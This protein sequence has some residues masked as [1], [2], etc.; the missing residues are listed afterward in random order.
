MTNLFSTLAFSALIA[1]ALGVF[2]RQ[3]GWG[4]ALPLLAAGA[5]VGVAPIGPD[6]PPEPEVVLIAVLAPL[7]FGEALGSS[8]LDLRKV[9]RPVLALA[10]GLV[11]ATTLIVGA[12]ASLV[13][14]MPIAMAFALGAVL[15]PTDAVAVS[16]VARRA[17]LPRRLVSILEGESLVNDGTGLTALK[18]AIVAAAAGSVTLAE[19][20]L[21]F[22]LA[23]V[24]GVGVG[25]IGG[26]ALSWVL[27]RAKD[28]VSANALVLVAPFGLY[29]IAEDFEGSGILA[30]VV[31][32]LII[33]NRQTSD[34]GHAGR[35]QS[36]NLWKHITF[37]L[38]CLAFFLVGM[39]IPDVLGRTKEDHLT[40]LL[41]LVPVVLVTLIVVRTLF[42]FGM[43]GTSR[44][45]RR[46]G[47]NV[48]RGAIILSWAGARGPV[49]GLAAFSIPVVFASGQQVPFRDLI[50][51]TAFVI[52]VLTLLLSLTLAPLARALRVP[53]DD[54]V[55]LLARVDVRLARAALDRLTDVE[56]EAMEAGTPMD[57]A[58]SERLREAAE[59][60]LEVRSL[61]GDP[62]TT[63]ELATQ[64]LV[65]AA[66]AMIRAEQEELIAMRDG[67][68][69]PDA[70]VRPILQ[71]LDLR[72]Q[73]LRT[74]QR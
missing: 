37:A 44:A 74:E 68:G 2:L 27:R 12:V 61:P 3:R 10:I 20:S 42:V 62:S 34:P 26:V 69:L 48:T 5:I 30:V 63:Q 70:L 32:A 49:S 55:D 52:I 8:Y 33:A 11:I 9:S 39:E 58:V 23:V 36:V 45:A 19:M 24:V 25:V 13:V 14:A 1:V 41:I 54:D 7:V 53:P 50:L 60:R 46:S 67:E 22:T 15:A 28:L 73:A 57:A 40:T 72:D 51:A 18:I 71:Q 17:G 47:A 65:A 29:L 64:Q 4:I 59:Q 31:A 56:V 43:V 6:A 21:V 16:T 66:R 38:Q 35:V